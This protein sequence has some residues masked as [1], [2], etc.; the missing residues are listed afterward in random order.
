MEVMVRRGRRRD[1]VK[2]GILFLI[3]VRLRYCSAARLLLGGNVILLRIKWHAKV[4]Y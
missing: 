2:I 3:A 1:F 4:F